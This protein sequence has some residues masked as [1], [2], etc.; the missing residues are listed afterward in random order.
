[1]ENLKTKSKE[2]KKEIID[3]LVKKDLTGTVIF[4]R[5]KI[6]NFSGRCIDHEVGGLCT[7]V[8]IT[9]HNGREIDLVDDFD[10][11]LGTFDL[12]NFGIDFLLTLLD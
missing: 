8:L 10:E 2:L 7:K 5:D 1:M 4:I 3:L 6:S 11:E 12:D 9:N